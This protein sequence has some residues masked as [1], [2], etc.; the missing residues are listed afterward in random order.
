MKVSLKAI[1]RGFALTLLLVASTAAAFAQTPATAT[2]RGQ[3]SDEFGGAIIGATVTAADASGKPKTVQTDSEGNFAIAGLVPGTY[4]VRVVSPGFA[5][6]ENVV[7][8]APGAVEPL[9]IT[10]GVSLEKEEVTVASEA[11]ISIDNTSPGAIVLKGKDLDALPDDPDELAAALQALAG[12]SA[13]PNGGQITIDGFEGGRIPPKDSIREVRVNDNPLSAERDQPGFG[14]IQIFTKPGTDKLRVSINSSFADEA[15]NSRNPFAPRREDYQFRRLG[16]NVSGTIVPKRASF[17]F[18]AERAVTDDNDIINATVVDPSTLATSRFQQTLLT[19][20]RFFNM[21]PRFDLALNKDHT[22][23]TRYGYFRSEVEGNGLGS[24]FA[25]PTRAFDSVFSQHNLQMTETAVINATTINETRFQFIRS[26]NEQQ[27]DIAQPGVNVESAFFGGS[28]QVGDSYNQ[29]SR[30]EV[31]NITTIA[32]GAQTFKFGGRLRGVKIED[33][34]QQNFGGTYSFFGGGGLT[35]IERYRLALQ[36]PG[37]VNP[38]TTKPYTPTELFNLGALPSQLTI[39]AGEPLAEVSQIDFGGFFQ[40][41]WKVRPNLTLGAGLRYEKQ[42]NIDSS[43]NFAPR[44]YVAWAPDGTGGRQAKTVIRFGIGYFFDR[45]NESFTLQTLRFNGINQQ[46]YLINDPTILAD[47][48]AQVGTDGVFR[49]PTAAQLAGFNLPQTTRVTAPD[50]REPYSFTTGLFVERQ[51]TK[52]MT[53]NI[54]WI[55]F[56]TKHALRSR[57]LNALPPGA[58]TA[59]SATRAH[60]YQFESSGTQSMQNFQ[61]GFSNRFNPGLTLSGFYSLGKFETDTDGPFSLPSD[62]TNLR[63][64]YSRASWDVRHRLFMLASIG[65]P[66]LKLMLN[67]VVV[68]NSSRPF[69]IITGVD[70]NGD[71]SLTERPSLVSNTTCAGRTDVSTGVVCTPYGTFNLRPAAGE[72]TISRN[73]GKGPNFV[74]VNLGISR[75]W[76]FGTTAA[77]RAAAEAKKKQEET[78]RAE[79]AQGGGGQRGG[80]N[81]GGGGAGGAGGQGGGGGIPPMRGPG[82]MMMGGNA[83]GGSEKKYNMTFSLNFQNLLNRANLGTPVGNLSSPFFGQSLQSF[84][85]GF[86]V[87]GG[88]GGAGGGGGSAAA[89]N[90]RVTASVRFNF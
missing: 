25:L 19:P 21:N 34:S 76:G 85:G 51:L 16:G 55:N 60:V 58:P 24:G 1:G 26:R 39:A 69:N 89:G 73:F 63:A 23:T 27:G 30:W 17:F 35:S 29:S 62:Y 28:S 36:L 61:I 56:R 54:G 5:F 80:G 83:F 10:L 4:N 48:S 32:R 82:M 7:E 67:P 31:T 78:R 70:T 71:G 41:D 9:K 87:I 79:R 86:M 3:V 66:K 49:A 11:P 90:R 65:I 12:P 72:Q 18:D 88:P 84:G 42:S 6:Y 40:D 43:M 57:D 50:L 74:S 14:G 47:L 52:T 44:L 15:L 59:P 45:F 20:R 81:R 33:F 37:T 53:M 64:D 77:G 75:S 22:L 8:V 68:A 13:G 38:A 46:Q 2:L